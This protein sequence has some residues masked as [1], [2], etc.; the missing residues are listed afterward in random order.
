MET[1]YL[2]HKSSCLFVQVYYYSIIILRDFLTSEHTALD[3]LKLLVFW[4]AI[5][6]F[7]FLFWCCSR[8][9][10]TSNT[11][12]HF[13]HWLRLFLFIHLHKVHFLGYRITGFPVL[14]WREITCIYRSR[15][16]AFICCFVLVALPP[17]P[18]QLLR[19]VI[20]D[21]IVATF[22]EQLACKIA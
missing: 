20:Y 22:F 5:G 7:F 17:P 4:V 14:Y 8:F 12:V 18:P 16:I 13:S 1:K 21:G 2:L 19:K 15:R 10:F 9:H 11:G 3:P 6:V